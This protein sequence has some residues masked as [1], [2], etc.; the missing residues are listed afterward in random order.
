MTA[1]ITLDALHTAPAR[2][3]TAGR[4]RRAND[5]P[6]GT[7]RQR[8]AEL[9]PPACGA[10][11]QLGHSVLCVYAGPVSGFDGSGDQEAGHGGVGGEERDCDGGMT[12]FPE[13]SG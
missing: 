10:L 12:H 4:E 3:P 5:R 6:A 8:R 13:R 9:R 7:G 1:T 2:R 11:R